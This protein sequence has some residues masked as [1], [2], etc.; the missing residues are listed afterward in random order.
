M[1]EVPEGSEDSLV[2][3]CVLVASLLFITSRPRCSSSAQTG[4]LHV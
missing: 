3:E 1:C 4:K 2:A